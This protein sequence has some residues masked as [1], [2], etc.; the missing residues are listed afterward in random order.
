MASDQQPH[1]HGRAVAL[2]PCPPCPPSS[3]AKMSQRPAA[4]VRCG[5]PN[6]PTHSSQLL[7][8]SCTNAAGRGLHT[9]DGRA[10]HPLSR[11]RHT[12]QLSDICHHSFRGCNVAPHLAHAHS[13]APTM[14]CAAA[15]WP[16]IT[17]RVSL[18][19]RGML[20][21]QQHVWCSPGQQ[22]PTSTLPVNHTTIKITTTANH[23]HLPPAPRPCCV[24]RC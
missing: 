2:A 12:L 19:G 15:R 8:A 6:P 4:G 24:T 20:P 21:H 11:G 3:K 18:L 1:P 16:H 9:A 13:T 7:Q 14:L 5:T 17:Q 22:R 10:P 23:V